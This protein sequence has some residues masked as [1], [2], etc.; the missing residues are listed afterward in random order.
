MTVVKS[1]KLR[2]LKMNTMDYSG[3]RGGG[4]KDWKL[5]GREDDWFK[6]LKSFK[7]LKGLK[8]FE[9]FEHCCEERQM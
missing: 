6:C 8:M 4:W 3:L 1:I 9:M 2:I 5:R 7:C